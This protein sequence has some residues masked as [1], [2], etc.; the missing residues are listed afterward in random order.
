MQWETTKVTERARLKTSGS[1]PIWFR[2]AT[3]RTPAIPRNRN[4]YRVAKA[5]PTRAR[6]G[7]TRL[8]GP[9]CK[10]VS[11]MIKWAIIFAVI[12]VVAGIFGFS[13]IAADS[14]AVARILFYLALVIFVVLL[15]LGLVV[16]RKLSK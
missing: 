13:G 9:K 12:S 5:T 7:A 15:V 16:G 10:E 2:R 1:R 11:S 14:A 4:P 6:V 8:G 3:R